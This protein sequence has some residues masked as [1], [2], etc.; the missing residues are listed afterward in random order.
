MVKDGERPVL[1]TEMDKGCLR[2]GKWIGSGGKSMEVKW[3]AIS[4]DRWRLILS[5]KYMSRRWISPFDLF[6]ATMR[7]NKTST[8]SNRA[9]VIYLGRE[10]DM[11]NRRIPM[12]VVR[13]DMARREIGPYIERG[14]ADREGYD[15]SWWWGGEVTPHHV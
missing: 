8:E 13:E 9:D 1:G 12:L 15:V 3:A 7:Y 6:E 5:W 11:R 10:D 14:H 2:N 4:L